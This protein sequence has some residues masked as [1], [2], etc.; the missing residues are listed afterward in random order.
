[1][2]RKLA[3]AQAAMA[4]REAMFARTENTM[5]ARDQGRLRPELPNCL[6]RA[7]ISDSMSAKGAFEFFLPLKASNYLP[8]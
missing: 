5:K 7:S 1:V 4:E 6:L 3:T 8:H 2:C